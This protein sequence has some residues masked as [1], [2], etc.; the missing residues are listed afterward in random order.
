MPQVGDY[1][2]VTDWAGQAIAVIRTVAV[3]I[4][5]FGEIDE[6]FARSEGE[7][8]LTLEWWRAAHRS[9]YERVLSGSPHRVDAELQIACETFEVALKA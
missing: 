6:K 2:I 9:Y 8:D 4:K 5:K 7:G 3:E 1:A